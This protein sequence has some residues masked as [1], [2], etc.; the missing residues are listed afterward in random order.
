M[1]L[2]EKTYMEPKELGEVF[3]AIE[4]LTN[5]I[6][7][8]GKE[9]MAKAMAELPKVIKAADGIEK[10][11]IEVKSPEVYEASGAFTGRMTK[12]IVVKAGEDPTPELVT[13]PEAPATA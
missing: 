5:A 1:E 8:G 3:D 7:N 4:G 11:K 6:V 10:V 13:E 9:K 2:R 12:T